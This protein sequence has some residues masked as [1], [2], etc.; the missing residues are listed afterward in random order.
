MTI[1]L[2]CVGDVHLGR[3]PGQLPANLRAFGLAAHELTPAVAWSHTVERA[4]ED[5]VDVV[6][7]AG[8]VVE[9]VEDRFEA[10]GHLERGVAR[11]NEVGIAV[12]GVAGNHDVEALP[13]LADRLPG[14]L[15]LGRGGVWQSEVLEL[16]G[17]RALRVVGWSFPSRHHPG[18]PL[19]GLPAVPTDG[20]PTVGFLHTDLDA[21]A[22]PYAPTTR[23]ALEA[24]AHRAWFLGHVHRPDDLDP[25][26]P[27]GYLGSLAGLDPGEPG[28]RGPWRVDLSANGVVACEQLPLAPLRYERE[29][30]ELGDEDRGVPLE[31]RVESELVSA[32]ERIHE[33]VRPTSGETRAVSCRLRFTGHA[34]EAPE[35]RKL[36]AGGR[37]DEL[38]RV[39]DDIVY[40]IDKLSNHVRAAY[41]LER[42]ARSSDPPGLLA[43]RL[44]TLEAG[45]READVLCTRARE[46][47][48][49]VEDNPALWGGLGTADLSLEDVRERLL[50]AGRLALE[51]LVAQ[52]ERSLVG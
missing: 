43:R 52:G 16:S 48:V 17:D 35:L 9:S 19:T 2:L 22:S 31:D 45:G 1:R 36:L 32:L 33:R 30:L 10:Y 24:T 28:V 20:L 8:D 26:R 12:C 49:R 21:G 34:R 42:M 29:E 11:L 46:E 44:L 41:D 5:S 14:F 47:L 4:I 27:I 6:A 18:D 25:A 23:A 15:L 13:R 38:V 50:R 37:F 40:F 51:E 3:R 7:F 39:Q